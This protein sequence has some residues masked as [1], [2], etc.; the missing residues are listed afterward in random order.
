MGE[1]RN[2]TKND[3]IQNIS[4]LEST[5]LCRCAE[6]FSIVMHSAVVKLNST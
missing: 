1:K 3:I 5:P 4:M 6:T 2:D